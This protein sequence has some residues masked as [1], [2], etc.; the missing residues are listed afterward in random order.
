ES[1]RSDDAD[2]R[3]ESPAPAWVLRSARANHCLRTA[4]VTPPCVGWAEYSRSLREGAT[5]ER[6]GRHRSGMVSA[7]TLR[8]GRAEPA[9]DERQRGSPQ[10]VPVRSH[11]VEIPL[12]RCRA[13]KLR[14]AG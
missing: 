1:P 5:R 12:A 8:A 2:R 7:E 6:R 4:F 3:S 11:W 9:A 14:I 10:R 13:F